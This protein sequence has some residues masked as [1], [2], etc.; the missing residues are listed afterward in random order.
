MDQANDHQIKLILNNQFEN[1][2][3]NHNSYKRRVNIDQQL[4]NHIEFE[5]AKE[6]I[7]P[8]PHILNSNFPSSIILNREAPPQD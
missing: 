3:Q 7:D 8:N 6:Q 1:S 5:E 2:P 4:P